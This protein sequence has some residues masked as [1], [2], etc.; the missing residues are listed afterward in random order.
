VPSVV[1]GV[2]GGVSTRGV[3]TVRLRGVGTRLG[4][5]EGLAEED[6]EPFVGVLGG[7]AG[8]GPFCFLWTG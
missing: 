4:A 7:A 3:G 8:A 6:E 1:L 2:S 5:G